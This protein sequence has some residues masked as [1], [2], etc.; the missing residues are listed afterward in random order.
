MHVG[1]AGLGLC[2][3]SWQLAHNKGHQ[4]PT[5]CQRGEFERWASVLVGTC[6]YDCFPLLLPQWDHTHLQGGSPPGLRHMAGLKVPGSPAG[7]R[8]RLGDT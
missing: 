4:L 2:C 6:C 8:R 7:A 5:A 1:V 3:A